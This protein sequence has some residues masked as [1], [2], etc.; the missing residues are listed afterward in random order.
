M[1]TSQNTFDYI[2]VGAGS[3]GCA[4]AARLSEDRGATVLLLEA[5]GWDHDPLNRIPMLWARNAFLRRHDWGYSCEPEK[6]LSG[7]SL[8]MFRGKIVG[9]SSSI[10]AMTYVRGH[11]ADYDRWAS[12]GLHDWSYTRVLPYFKKQETWEGGG[13]KYRGDDGPLTTST[14]RY[15]DTLGDAILAAGEAAGHPATADYNGAQQEGFASAQLTVLDGHRCSVANGYLAPVKSRENLTVIVRAHAMKVVVENGR[16][17]GVAYR[18]NGEVTTARAGREVILC[19][20]SINSPQLLMLS[21]IGDPD[22]LRENSIDAKVPLRGV[23]KNLREHLTVDVGYVRASPGPLHRTMRIDRTLFALGSAYFLR[24]GIFTSVPN[25][26]MAF[27]KAFPDSEIPDLQLQ[28][29]MGPTAASPYLEPFRAPYVD[30]FG[31]RPVLLRPESIGQLRL[32]SANPFEPIRIDL[33]LYAAERDR[34]ALRSGIRLARDIL[35]QKPLQNF[36]KAEVAPGVDCNSDADLDAYV[37]QSAMAFI[38]PLG[39]CKMGLPHDE[40]AVVDP[41]LRVYGVEGL[42]VA[43]ASIMPDHIG[44]NLNAPVVMVAEKAADMIR[45]GAPE[46][47]INV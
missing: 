45:G 32:R 14:S 17:Q 3:A 2:I 38:H 18:K 43:D 31:C 22:D 34:K 8:P 33:N 1:A 13:D 44:A 6:M 37:R 15:D 28:F 47:A 40:T 21:G 42:R 25:H 4:L 20:G 39:T 41:E 12:Y 16:A 36:A 23:G 35:R 30:G 27:L 9:G 46:P 11:R 10:N 19:G 5:G 29:R 26:V 24:K 7:Q